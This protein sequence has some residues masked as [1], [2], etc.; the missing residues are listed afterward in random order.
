MNEKLEKIL[1]TILLII[2]I[3]CIIGTIYIFTHPKQMEYFTEFYILGPEGK[4]YDYPTELYVN[5]T[6]SVIIGIVNHEGKVMNYT[7]EIW[8]VNGTYEN[9]SLII[10]N[11]YFL[12]KFNVTLPPKPI[13]IEK[14]EP[15]F[16]KRY[17]FTISK[18]GNYQLW[19]LLFKGNY[20]KLPFKLVKWK[21]YANTTAKERIYWAEENKILSLKLNIKVKEI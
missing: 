20:P 10:H 5:E 12:D 21:D 9:G 7:V 14:W 19:F 3:L 1:T 4:A 15:Q 16:E 13:S 6:G 11:M 2:L 18:P 17:N 8:L